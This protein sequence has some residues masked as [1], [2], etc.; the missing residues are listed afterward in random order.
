MSLVIHYTEAGADHSGS[1]NFDYANMSDVCLVLE[2]TFSIKLDAATMMKLLLG[3]SIQA[4]GM[5]VWI[6][7]DVFKGT[8]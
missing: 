5:D 2:K 7:E 1:M 8:L 6:I 4:Q 3:E